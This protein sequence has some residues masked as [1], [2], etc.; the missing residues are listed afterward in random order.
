M[1]SPESIVEDVVKVVEEVVVVDIVILGGG[2]V[3]EV[4]TGEAV[5]VVVVV[6]VG[7]AVVLG[8]VVLGV[9]AAVVGVPSLVFFGDFAVDLESS[10]PSRFTERYLS[11]S[12]FLTCLILLKLMC[13]SVSVGAFFDPPLSLNS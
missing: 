12:S 11:A 7:E 5:L 1:G 3:A 2:G 13:L 6:V 9:S 8:G 4:V 10:G